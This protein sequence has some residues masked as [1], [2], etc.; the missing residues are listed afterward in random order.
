[1]TA[2]SIQRRRGGPNFMLLWHEFAV[3]SWSLAPAVAMPA[4]G[5]QD[6]AS[7]SL[8]SFPRVSAERPLTVAIVAP[9]PVPF[10]LGGAENLWAGWLA[11]MNARA[12][13]QAEL[14]KLPSPEADF[15]SVVDSY[16]RFAALDLDHFDRVISTKYPAW[17]VGHRDHHVYLQHKLRGLYDTWP[18]GLATA[19]PL[20]ASAP[21]RELRRRLAAARG[22]RAALPGIFAALEALRGAAAELPAELFR[23]PGALIREVVHTLD[24]IGLGRQAVRRYA[25]ISA[26]V[27]AR[28]AYFPPAVEVSREVQVLHH[29]TLPRPVGGDSGPVPAGAIF[30][31]SRLDGPKRMDWLV[32]AHHRA[33]LDIPLCIAGEGPQRAALEAAI[34][35]GQDVRL[36]GRISDAALARAYR[37]AA[38]VAYVPDR[39]D[40]GLI[41]LEALQAGTPVLGC[42]DSGGVTELLRDGENGLLVAPELNALAAGMRRL[43]L[44]TELRQRLARQARA[45]VAHIRWPALVDAFATAAPRIAVLNTFSFVPAVSGGKLR[46]W[47][48]Y[49]ELAR[50][51]DLRCVNLVHA[52]A[53]PRQRTLAP[54]LVEHCVPMSAAHAARQQALEQSLEASCADVAALIHAPL[55]PAWVR[56]V[57]AAVRWADIVILSHP[58]GWGAL[59]AAGGAGDTPLVYEAHNVEADLKQA[60]L[61]AGSEA[62]A[63]VV[64]AEGACARSAA[65]VFCCSADDAARLQAL[66]ALDARPAVAPNGVDG[67]GYPQL[68]DDD[69]AAARRRLGLAVDAPLALFVGSLHGPNLDAAQHVAELAGAC[70]GWQFCLLGSVCDGAA[71]RR[72]RRAGTLPGNLALVGR[73]GDAELRAWLAAA[74]VGLNPVDSGSGTNLKLL[75]YAAAGLAALSTP[76]GGRGGLLEAETHY[77]CADLQDFAEALEALHPARRGER[78]RARVAAARRQARAA[79]DW[80]RIAG[81]M[82]Q[83][84]LPLLPATAGPPRK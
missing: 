41:T 73:V 28:E 30:S 47:H 17:M 15:W 13:I 66:Y 16:R 4:R 18:P 82:W 69:R 54:G 58:Y 53:E 11:A 80:R 49:R 71:L 70:P 2:S 20:P 39:E 38:F 78:E 34:A 7:S 62:L 25:A 36:L 50:R 51:A 12:H 29:P 63:A 23:L 67:H 83:A 33:R 45:S 75:E 76:F 61:G 68:D 19:A 42:S 55:S 31:A 81:A 27:A 22:S 1:M 79:G 46:M 26:T 48:L 40:Y 5:G 6:S 74:D 21:L 9:S 57:A 37:D 10:A 64:D 52:G 77:A 56:A 3:S 60:I 72:A 14:I 8:R 59:C 35:P 32:A 65:R 44:D 84:L 43:A 24:D